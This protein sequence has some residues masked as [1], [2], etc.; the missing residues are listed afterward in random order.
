MKEGWVKNGQMVLKVTKV[1]G[2]QW[3]LMSL[4]ITVTLMNTG[5]NGGFS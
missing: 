3:L 1:S 2:E 4:R 5:V